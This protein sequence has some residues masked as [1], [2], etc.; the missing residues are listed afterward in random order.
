MARSKVGKR[1]DPPVFRKSYAAAAL[2]RATATDV[3]TPP[4]APEDPQHLAKKAKMK[5]VF[6]R[7]LANM[8]PVELQK[9]L[10]DTLAASLVPKER[11]QPAVRKRLERMTRQ[12]QDFVV[13]ADIPEDRAFHETTFVQHARHFVRTLVSPS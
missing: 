5:T 6:G 10:A 2:D 9:L 3:D 4:P 11:L 7:T 8:D 12:W 13:M 1:K